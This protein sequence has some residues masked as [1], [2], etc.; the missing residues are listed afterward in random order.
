MHQGSLVRFLA[1]QVAPALSSRYG[2]T[3]P[4]PPLGSVVSFPMPDRMVLYGAEATS[5]SESW[6]LRRLKS[7][8]RRQRAAR[9]DLPRC[10]RGDLSTLDYRNYDCPRSV[11]I[12]DVAIGQAVAGCLQRLLPQHQK[13][14]RLNWGELAG[15]DRPRGGQGPSR[16]VVAGSGYLLFDAQGRLASRV[17][18]DVEAF[19]RLDTTIILFGIGVNRP[20]TRWPAPT[21]AE[22]TLV[23][24]D[25]ETLER[26]LARA[27]AVSARDAQTQTLLRRFTTDD[28]DLIGDPA[29]HHPRFCPAPPAANVRSTR[30]HPGPGPIVGLNLSFHGPIP[31][32]LLRNN[33]P[34]YVRVLQSLQART[35]CRFRYIQHHGAERIVPALLARH[36]LRFELVRGHPTRLLAAYGSLDL[37]LGGML[38]SCILASAMD[39]PCLGLS[40]D[41]KHQGFFELMG[42]PELCLSATHFEPDLLLDRALQILSAPAPVR[43]TIQARRLALEH[44]TRQFATQSLS[45]LLQPSPSHQT[46][47]PNSDPAS[48][49][50]I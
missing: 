32:L 20:E 25:A 42:L 35:G 49:L 15:L 46:L 7:W 14:R 13:L 2:P 5:R 3:T 39:T 30:A 29:L 37:H 40:Y 28:V 6:R 50:A 23:P 27:Q 18:R 45:R 41:I 12:G 8:L 48:L 44:R 43:T 9:R 38:H 47:V 31:N 24:E 19:E 33:F 36:G 21:D 34:G 22:P 26:L 17:R 1:E 16:I 10:E 11:N 4:F